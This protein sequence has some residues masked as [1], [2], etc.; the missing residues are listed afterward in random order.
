MDILRLKDGTEIELQT[1]ASLS[2]LSVLSE[3]KIEMLGTWDIL[4]DDN[5]SEASII[6][7]NGLLVGIYKNLTLVSE[8]SKVNTDG[9]I[10][11]EYNLRE[12]TQQEIDIE[13][14]KNDMALLSESLNEEA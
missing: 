14:L 3:N 10:L 1:G 7:G 11:T 4:T 9:S 12:K 13:D 2:A 5:L 6:N 8:T